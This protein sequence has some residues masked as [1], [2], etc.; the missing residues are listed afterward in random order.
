[1]SDPFTPSAE[2][3]A[4]ARRWL[5]HYASRQSK[6]VANL[7]SGS[8][9]WT[10]VGSDDNEIW[11]GQDLCRSFNAYTDEQA[12]LILED[13]KV[14]GFE[15]GSFGWACATFTVLSENR[16]VSSFFRSTFVFTLEDAVWKIVHVHNSV[17]KAS[18]ESMGYESRSL[19]E[20][21][22]SADVGSFHIGR[23][24]IASVMF[25]DIVGSTALAAAMGDAAWSRKIKAHL[26]QIASDIQKFGGTL[27]KSLGDGTL[28]SFTSAQA[29]MRAAQA[30]QRV[31]A[32]D[33]EEPN[34]SIRI[35]IHTGDVV[36]SGG[37]YLGSVVNK[38]ARIAA[39]AEPD[40]IRVSDATRI[41]VGAAPGFI[42]SG[43]ETT[44]LKGLEGDHTF[45]RLEWRE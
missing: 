6:M 1:M 44:R 18:M 3:S 40:E 26:A 32:Q 19:D 5:Q 16:Q 30:I 39:I 37:D 10:Y 27:V 17:P 25:T 34:L 9:A 33:E 7:F 13:I 11:T 22:A 43:P 41:M 14:T 28:S 8:E 42:F 24:G 20:L 2:L 31:N 12:R 38:A 15:A 35:G 23:T 4:I 29:A 21:A 45:Y 36:Q